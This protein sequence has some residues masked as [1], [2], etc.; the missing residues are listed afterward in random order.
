MFTLKTKISTPKWREC[1]AFYEGV[2]GMK[3][4]EAWDEPDDRGAI[5]T[6]REGKQEAFLELYEVNEEHDLRGL[7]LQFKTPSITDFLASLSKSIPYEGPVRRPW[8]STYV[9]LRDP[10][11]TLVVVF[12]GDGL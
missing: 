7:S 4:A 3:V 9:Y 6:F 12:E 2:F 10:A 8:G 11:G 1:V 5:L